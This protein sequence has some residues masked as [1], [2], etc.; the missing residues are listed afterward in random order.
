MRKRKNDGRSTREMSCRALTSRHML[1]CYRMAAEKGVWE[2]GL[3]SLNATEAE[4]FVGGSA[5]V[6]LPRLDEASAFVMRGKGVYAA[7]DLGTNNCRLLVAR[8]SATARR[9]AASFASSTPFR[10]SSG[11]AR[12]WRRPAASARPRSARAIAAL[13]ICR[14]KMRAREVTRARLIATEACRAAE[15]G[16]EFSQP[17]RRRRPASSSRSSIRETEARL[18]ATG[19]TALLDPAG[20]GR[21]AVRHRR[22]LLRTGAARAGRSAAARGPP[23]ADDAPAG[24]R[25]RSAS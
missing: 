16:E 18:A 24:C 9:R 22:R 8:R 12:A 1:D 23:H 13:R 15:N 6:R 7:L 4:G 19:C 11:S 25:C 20:R 3:T 10:A 5:A 2:S 14:D 21:H 17:R